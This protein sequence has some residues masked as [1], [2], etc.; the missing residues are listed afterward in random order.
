MF[1]TNANV[2]T[3]YQVAVIQI[4]KKRLGPP[5][6]LKELAGPRMSLHGPAHRTMS[7]ADWIS[8][9]L[10]NR[11]EELSGCFTTKLL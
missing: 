6:G 7:G 1:F 5:F 2:Q 11:K 3:L 10:V 9:L 4:I 8:M